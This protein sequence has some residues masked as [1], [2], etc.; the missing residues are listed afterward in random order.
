[1]TSHAAA[2]DWSAPLRIG[3]AHTG[4]VWSVATATLPDGQTLII[5]GSTDRTVRRWDATTGQPVGDPLT[6]HTSAVWSVTTATLPDGRTLIISGSADWTLVLWPVRPTG[7]VVGEVTPP[8]VT[9]AVSRTDD[10]DDDSFRDILGRGVLA[11]HLEELLVRLTSRQRAGTA[12]V[13]ID[14]RWGSGKSRLVTLLERRLASASTNG[15]PAYG[16]QS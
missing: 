16:S 14:G 5:S 13:H 2:W 1:V 9:E 6:G 10:M 11:A 3:P 4:E 12:V 7:Q 15:G 8:P